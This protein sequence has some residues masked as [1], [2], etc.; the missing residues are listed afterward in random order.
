MQ[1][2][3]TFWSVHRTEMHSNTITVDCREWMAKFCQP[4][5]IHRHCIDKST[6]HDHT[7]YSNNDQ[8][9]CYAYIYSAPANA[10]DLFQQKK[11]SSIFFD[12]F[13]TAHAQRTSNA[14]C[15]LQYTVTLIELYGRKMA[16]MVDGICHWH[17]KRIF[18]CCFDIMDVLIR[19]KGW[20]WIWRQIVIVSYHNPIS[21]KGTF[22]ASSFLFFVFCFVAFNV[23]SSTSSMALILFFYISWTRTLLSLSRRDTMPESTIIAEHTFNISAWRRLFPAYLSK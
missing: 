16:W 10:G 7:I 9:Q 19:A 23:S 13:A 22:F 20:C 3:V 15:T 17:M 21:K 18:C 1:L 11:D 8:L 5:C 6:V 4:R 12:S 14:H 2:V